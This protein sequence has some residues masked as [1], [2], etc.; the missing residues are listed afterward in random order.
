MLEQNETKVRRLSG[1]GQ[2]KLL[3]L[4]HK[5]ISTLVNAFKSDVFDPTVC[6]VR[7]EKYAS[8][9]DKVTRDEQIDNHP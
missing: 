9:C 3:A 2:K 8:S 6:S 4:L 5:K 1:P 7:V